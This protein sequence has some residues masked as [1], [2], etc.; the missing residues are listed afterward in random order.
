MDWIIS[1]FIKRITPYGP[2]QNFINRL[3][4]RK[5]LKRFVCIFAARRMKPAYAAWYDQNCFCQSYNDASQQQSYSFSKYIN[6]DKNTLFVCSLCG[7][8]LR[9]GCMRK[10]KNGGY[11]RLFVLTNSLK[12][13]FIRFL[14]TAFPFFLDTITANRSY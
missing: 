3:I 11:L 2:V 7:K 6:H 12:I 5:F 8:Q 10:S 14:S 9:S 4:K 13:L 1:A